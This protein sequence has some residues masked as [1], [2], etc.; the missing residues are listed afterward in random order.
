MIRR[1]PRSTLFPYTTLFRSTIWQASSPDLKHWS[2]PRPVVTVG[3]DP[4][5]AGAVWAPEVFWEASL[6][7][8]VMA[9]TGNDVNFN[10]SIC[11]AYSQNLVQWHKAPVNPIVQADT[12]QYIWSS[13]SQ[14]SDFRDPFVYRTDDTWHMLVTAKQEPAGVKGVLYHGTSTDLNTWTDIGPFFT[15]DG[16]EGWRALESSQYFTIGSTHHLLFGEFDTMGTTLLSAS[17]PAGWTMDNRVT[18]DFGYAPEVD[19]FDPGVHIYSRLANFYLPNDVDIGYVVRMDTLLTNP[20][21]SDPTVFLPHPMD[22]NWI[23]RSG[24]A[25][26]ANP[27]FGDNPVWRGAPSVGLVGN[28]YY[29]S[30]EYYQGPLSERG[31]PGTALGDATTGV[32]E[33]K[34]FQVTGDRMTLLVGGGD[35]PETCYVALIDAADL[36]V[37][38]RET[39]GGNDLMTLREWNLTPY[40]GRTCF[41]TIV[42]D[43]KSVV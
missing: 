18:L 15:N 7:R 17:S 19:E 20:D 6:D 4:W 9:Y 29:A 40:Q 35:Y 31:S 34:R 38:H 22:E 13:S 24:T 10:Q 33:S 21:G 2:A 26:L 12:T 11:F 28:S 25:N 23:V 8:W 32:A 36:T 42:E 41:I 30:H 37:I 5:D 39:G 27:T 1:P 14:W 43:R 3:N 16:A